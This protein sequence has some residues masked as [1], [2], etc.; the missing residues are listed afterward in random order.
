MMD[1]AKL[2]KYLD[3]IV[4]NQDVSEGKPHPE[5]Y[6]KAINFFEFKAAECLVVEDNENGVKAA[7]TAGAHVL[8]VRSVDETNLENI[9]ERIRRIETG[10]LNGL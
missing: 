10:I 1:K 7:R 4:S 3:L 9:K 8:E 2:D 5:I 6:R